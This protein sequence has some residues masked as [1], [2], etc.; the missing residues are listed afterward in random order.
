[1]LL[2]SPLLSFQGDQRGQQQKC[3]SD[4]GNSLAT[5]GIT[6]VT[7]YSETLHD[8]EIRFKNENN[9]VWVA[10]LGRGLDMF[11][12]V[13]SWFSLGATDYAYRLCHEVTVTLTRG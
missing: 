8:R 12:K 3:M 10:I 11:K 4:L 5:R 7:N 9:V 13:N 6:F 2:C 1:M